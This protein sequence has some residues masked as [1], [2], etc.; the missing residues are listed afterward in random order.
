MSTTTTT[1]TSS[2]VPAR[3][4]TAATT[5]RGA[6]GGMIAAGVMAMFAM[7]ASVTYQH[8]GFFTPLFHISALFG[9]PNPMMRSAEQ[10]MADHRFWFDAGP[11]V[12]GL[13]IHMVTGAMFGMTFA[14]LTTRLRVPANVLT[15]AAYGL[16]V[17]VMSAFVGLP[18]AAKV[19]GS[20]STIAD[21]ASMVGW[22]TFAAEHMMFGAALGAL[23]RLAQR[24]GDGGGVGGGVQGG[25]GS[26][27]L[28]R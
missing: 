21:M 7:V 18:I 10:A 6:I 3:A 15:G 17:F 8:H 13:A 22:V 26:A 11:A 25:A 19:T 4:G 2:A 23:A 12:L 5:A 1:T 16:A 28:F 27:K 20:G 14:L 9:S 24:T